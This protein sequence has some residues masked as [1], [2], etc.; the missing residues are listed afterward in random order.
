MIVH[1][2]TAL[3]S[4][5]SSGVISPVSSKIKFAVLNLTQ[6]ITAETSM[7]AAEVTSLQKMILLH[8]WKVYWFESPKPLEIPTELHTFLLKVWC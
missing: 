4:W 8:L 2:M 7:V 6:L 5:R 1:M 3:V